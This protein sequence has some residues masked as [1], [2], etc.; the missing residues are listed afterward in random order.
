[1][2]L[3]ESTVILCCNAQ[4]SSLIFTNYNCASQYRPPNVGGIIGDGL[5]AA[6][7]MFGGI[8]GAP[9]G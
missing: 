6:G 4:Y 9:V 1:L 7:G 8:P 3:N 5:I 2:Y